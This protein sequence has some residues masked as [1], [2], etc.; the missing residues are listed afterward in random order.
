MVKVPVVKVMG[1]SNDVNKFELYV[2]PNNDVFLV[3]NSSEEIQ[4]SLVVVFKTVKLLKFALVGTVT[5]KLVAEAA[6]ITHF[7]PP[8]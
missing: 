5:V 8:K 2:I 3:T 1:A 4:L 6:V 7:E